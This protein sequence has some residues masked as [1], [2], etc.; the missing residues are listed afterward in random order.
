MTVIYYITGHILS[1][2]TINSLISTQSLNILISWQENFK[3]AF[4]T[5]FSLFSITM[6][7]FTVAF[8]KKSN[9]QDKVHNGPPIA[10][11]LEFRKID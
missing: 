10:R 9:K 11:K 7:N 3:N 6:H 5:F 8:Y 1:K 4:K 2:S